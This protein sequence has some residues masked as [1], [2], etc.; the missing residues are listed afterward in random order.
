MR[1][2]SILR[3]FTISLI[4]MGVLLGYYATSILA[5]CIFV[6]WAAFALTSATFLQQ[7][8][9]TNFGRKKNKISNGCLSGEQH[10]GLTKSYFAFQDTAANATSQTSIVRSI[11][12]T[13][14]AAEMAA[15]STLDGG[16]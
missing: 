10:K 16:K 6:V 15:A 3:L 2:T 12:L 9:V 5:N 13:E 8:C 7:V 14:C 4:S 11:S 1:R